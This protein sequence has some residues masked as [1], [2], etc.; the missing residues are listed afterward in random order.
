MIE[1]SLREQAEGYEQLAGIEL[2]ITRTGNVITTNNRNI[3]TSSTTKEYL[4]KMIVAIDIL[5]AR[6]IGTVLFN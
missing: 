5:N 3:E 4:V 1:E 6:P 2:E